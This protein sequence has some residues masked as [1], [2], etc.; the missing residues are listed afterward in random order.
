MRHAPDMLAT[1]VRSQPE[2]EG[3]P[4]ALGFTFKLELKDGTPADPPSFRSA[5]GVSWEPG[6]TIPLGRDRELRVIHTRLDEGT[7]GDPVSVPVVE[8]A[9]PPKS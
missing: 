9:N 6:D 7:D 4:M 5:P 8:A 2:T 1:A 3:R